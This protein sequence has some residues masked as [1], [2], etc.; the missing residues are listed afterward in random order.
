MRDFQTPSCVTWRTLTFWGISLAALRWSA[1]AGEDTRVPLKIS[2]LTSAGDSQGSKTFAGAFFSALDFVNQNKSMLP[3]YRLEC[4][5]NDTDR[6]SLNA[7]NAMTSHYRNEIIAFIGPDESCHCESTVAAAWNLPMIGYVS[8]LLDI[9]FLFCMMYRF[10]FSGSLY[11]KHKLYFVLK[12]AVMVGLRRKA[13]R[14]FK[15]VAHFQVEQIPVCQISTRKFDYFKLSLFLSL[16]S[17]DGIES[18]RLIETL[19]GVF[20]EELFYFFY[21]LN[22]YFKFNDFTQVTLF[23]THS[24]CI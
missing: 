8:R 15:L 19:L 17:P 13:K 22:Y 6:S 11:I 12:F 7:I 3:G 14:Y 21:Y 2:F 23:E 24:T 9:M 1:S 16:F 20:W 5:F 10:I 4:L 18:M